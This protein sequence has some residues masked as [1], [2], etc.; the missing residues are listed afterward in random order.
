MATLELNVAD[1]ASVAI[2]VAELRERF[3]QLNV[4]INNAGISRA[5]DLLAESWDLD[6]VEATIATNVTGVLQ[7]TDP[8]AMPLD[9]YADEVLALL[10]AGSTPDGEVLVDRVMGYRAAEREGRYA[11]VF[12]RGNG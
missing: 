6:L 10:A 3:P 11:A 12:A 9:A 7:L 8:H 2:A 1:A 4:L 5:E